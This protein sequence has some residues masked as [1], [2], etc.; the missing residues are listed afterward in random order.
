MAL[1]SKKKETS[2]KAVETASQ[3]SKASAS[4]AK[5]S[6]GSISVRSR[7]PVLKGPRITEKSLIAND[8]SV[9]VFNVDVRATKTEIK[10]AIKRIYNVDAIDVRVLNHPGKVKRR[11]T[12]LGRTARSRKA[13]VQLKAGQTIELV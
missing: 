6:E 9:F 11:G 2:D 12:K 7:R 1:F 3:T 4:A 8:K 10:Q 5:S 13:Y